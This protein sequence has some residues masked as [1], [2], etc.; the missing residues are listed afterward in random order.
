LPIANARG[1]TLA[2]G[3]VLA[4]AT[5]GAAAAQSRWSLGTQIGSSGIGAEV[6]FQ[7]SP[8]FTVR[9]DYD[10]LHFDGTVDG[11]YVR[12]KGKF[13]ISVGG[14]FGDWHPWASNGFLFTAGAYIGARNA[15][16][17]AEL[18][19]V[20]N[21]GGQTFT[22]DQ[23]PGIK[24]KIKLD[25]FAPTLGLGYNNTFLHKHWGFKAVAGVVFSE[26]PKVELSR[27]NGPPIDGALADQVRA[28]FAAEEAK[29]QSNVA[30]LKTYPLIE[31]GVAYRF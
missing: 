7:A 26:Q 3:L 28:A 27:L 24:A 18:Q 1:W 10:Y 29:I 21:I 5:G 15:G 19:S 20:N 16:G 31:L 25:E 12:Y 30:I 8:H 2:A 23:V 14:I 11:D 9:G 6:G 17:G 13:D 22:L 4:V